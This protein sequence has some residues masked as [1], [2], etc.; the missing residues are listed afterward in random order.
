MLMQLRLGEVMCQNLIGVFLG[1]HLLASEDVLDDALLVDDESGANRAH[2]LLAIHVFLAPCAHRLQQ[3]VVNIGNQGERQFVLLLELLVRRSRVFAHTNHLIASPLQFLIV[4][5]QTASLSR[6]SARVVLRIEVQHQLPALVVTQTDVPSPFVL[7][8]YLGRFVS[9]VHVV[10][11]FFV[12]QSQRY[13]NF[14]SLT[15]KCRRFFV[16]ALLI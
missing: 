13:T 12:V 4:V 11:V 16:S 8:Q 10:V 7:A 15:K 3:R 6:A 2:R 5:S 1:L 9:D 14:L